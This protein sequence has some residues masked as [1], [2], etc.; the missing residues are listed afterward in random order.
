MTVGPWPYTTGDQAL[1]GGI[2]CA[3]ALPSEQ[4]SGCS[5][6]LV[7]TLTGPSGC[8]AHWGPSPDVN[9]TG[10]LYLCITIPTSYPELGLCDL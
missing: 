8:S 4:H 3:T 6:S 10:S 1:I 9:P 2:L 5:L 7:L